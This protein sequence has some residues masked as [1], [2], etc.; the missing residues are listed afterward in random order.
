MQLTL[1]RSAGIS[2][3]RFDYIGGSTIALKK[4]GKSVTDDV[5]EVEIITLFSKASLP[6]AFLPKAYCMPKDN[7]ISRA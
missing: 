2:D 6:V 4:I 1:M 3:E 7:V 5:C